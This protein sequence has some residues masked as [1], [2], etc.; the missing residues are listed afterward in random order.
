MDMLI[1][2]D[3]HDKVI[4]NIVACNCCSSKYVQLP[5]IRATFPGITDP[6][7]GV[8][9]FMQ[10]NITNWSTIDA[11]KA[12]LACESIILVLNPHLKVLDKASLR[13]APTAQPELHER[14]FDHWLPRTCSSIDHGSD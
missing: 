12:K 5:G 2:Y 14:L 6:R 3:G 1:R 8:N 11:R 7:I 4:M 10:S 9:R 13:P